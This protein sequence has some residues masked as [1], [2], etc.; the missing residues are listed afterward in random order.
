MT[1]PRPP[2]S[3]SRPIGGADDRRLDSPASGPATGNTRQEAIRTALDTEPV[4]HSTHGASLSRVGPPETI[5]GRPAQLAARSGIDQ[6]HPR[7]RMSANVRTVVAVELAPPPADAAPAPSP[8]PVRQDD[9]PDRILGGVAALLADRFDIDA[10]WVRIAFVLLALVGG[11][12]ILVY[13]ALWLA[14]VVGRDTDRRWAR[15][16]GGILLVLGLP[17]A[18]TTGF[19]FWDG[20]LAVFAL[21][22]GLAVALWSPRRAAADDTVGVPSPRACDGS[23]RHRHSAQARAAATVD[24]RPTDARDRRRRRRARS[25][26]RPGQRRPAASRAVARQRS[27]RVRDRSPRRRVRRSGA[28]ADHSRSRVRRRRLRRR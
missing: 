5:R 6:G 14:F 7:W 26:D 1:T 13:G 28:L 17:L 21:L 16:A 22:A 27:H 4:E 8:A 9:P 2:A 19:R 10:L 24:P 18:L 3:V 11:V 25:A 15:V 20:P 23:G 12:G